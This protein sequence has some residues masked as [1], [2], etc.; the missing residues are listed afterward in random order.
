TFHCIQKFE[1]S[2]RALEVRGFLVLFK[3][4]SAASVAAFCTFSGPHV[5]GIR[6][7]RTPDVFQ[8]MISRRLMS[9]NRRV[10][11]W[12]IDLIRSQIEPMVAWGL[13]FCFDASIVLLSLLCVVFCGALLFPGRA[14]GGGVG[15]PFRRSGNRGGRLLPNQQKVTCRAALVNLDENN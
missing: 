6:E 14:K 7:A 12:E 4:F 3:G 13:L 8:M 15:I 11:I 9:L 5:P 10:P 2:A 1:H